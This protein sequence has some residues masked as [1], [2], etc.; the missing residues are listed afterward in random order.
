M[1]SLA[2]FSTSSPFPHPSGKSDF[3]ISYVFNALGSSRTW[4]STESMLLLPPFPQPEP[5]R[6]QDPG[7]TFCKPLY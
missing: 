4:K 6:R 3:Y 7:S 5:P 2:Y 1:P